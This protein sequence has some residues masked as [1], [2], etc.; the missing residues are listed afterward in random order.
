M[1]LSGKGMLITL[2]DADPAEEQDFN[3]W[4]DKEH[5]IERVSIPGF[6]EARRYAAIAAEPK[7]LNLYT[8]EDV[9]VLRSPAYLEALRN[10]TPWTA[11]H[12]PKFRNF[13]RAVARVGLSRGQGRGGALA[14]SRIFSSGGDH[15]VL[16]NALLAKLDAVADRAISAH[17]LQ[18]DPELSRPPGTSASGAGTYDWYVFIEGTDERDVRALAEP[19][20]GRA[21][22]VP[23]AQVISFG[24]YRLLWDLAKAELL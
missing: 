21:A 23:G 3:R 6:L 7:Y 4:Y 17:L 5:I 12:M 14:F 16:R 10:P 11:H 18:A 8:V 20:F 15:G 1:P 9:D 22:A 13:T 2:M 24:T 19:H